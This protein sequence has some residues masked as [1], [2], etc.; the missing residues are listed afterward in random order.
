MSACQ[1]KKSVLISMNVSHWIARRMNSYVIAFSCCFFVHV[2]HGTFFCADVVVAFLLMY[3]SDFFWLYILW[4][5]SIEYPIDLFVCL[6]EENDDTV[7]H[8][9]IFVC[10]FSPRL[11]FILLMKQKP[12]KYRRCGQWYF[13][14]FH[15][16][17]A[18][19]IVNWFIFGVMVC[20]KWTFC[21]HF[22]L[23]YVVLV[24]FYWFIRKLYDSVFVIRILVESQLQN[25][26]KAKTNWK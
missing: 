20:H 13:S 7:K 25:G 16:E 21:L 26:M 6:L 14:S 12:S 5:F 9:V 2:S 22:Q 10:I 11:S 19:V 8:H 15:R 23:F 17:V 3:Y 18:I 1:S 4:Q 24:L